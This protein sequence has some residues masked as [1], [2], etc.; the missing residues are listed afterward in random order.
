[1]S[2]E[3][4]VWKNIGLKPQGGI[5]NLI[6]KTGCCT[7]LYLG[8]SVGDFS[9]MWATYCT[10][11]NDAALVDLHLPPLVEENFPSNLL[12]NCCPSQNLTPLGWSIVNTSNKPFFFT[13]AIF[14][15]PTMENTFGCLRIEVAN[16]WLR[17]GPLSSSWTASNGSLW[18]RKR[19]ECSWFLCGLFWRSFEGG[20]GAKVFSFMINEQTLMLLLFY[21]HHLGDILRLQVMFLLFLSECSW[22]SCRFKG[23]K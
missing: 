20:K 5:G 16:G 11:I 6:N 15:K 18:V 13:K 3:T 12:D 10:F 1:M 7:V 9:K 19:S 21:P 23:W 8:H 2:W 14:F 17:V 22:C 4:A